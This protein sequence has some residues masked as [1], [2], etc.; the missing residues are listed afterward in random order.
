MRVSHDCREIFHVS[1]TS[2]KLVAKVFNMFK[3]FM[4]IFSPKNVTILSCD[5][6]TEVHA[7]V[8][9][10]SVRTF[11]KFTVQKFWDTCTNV[12]QQSCDS[13]EKTCEH[14]M[15]IWQENNTKRHSYECKR[16]SYECRET[17]SRMSCDCRMNENETKVMN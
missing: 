12:L 2:R 5:S 17:L 16:H 15:T 11:C 9:N 1:R 10:P 6:H 7:S 4:G 14:L 8:V 3:N 13:L